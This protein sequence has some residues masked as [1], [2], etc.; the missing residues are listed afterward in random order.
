MVE[1]LKQNQD[2]S[3]ELDNSV[4]E[5]VNFSETKAAVDEAIQNEDVIGPIFPISSSLLE[6][7]GLAAKNA[8]KTVKVRTNPDVS[9]GAPYMER[10]HDAMRRIEYDMSDI[11]KM[12]DYIKWKTYED[13]KW[14][15]LYLDYI[16]STASAYLLTEIM[17]NPFM[18]TIEDINHAT[19]DIIRIYNFKSPETPDAMEY[20]EDRVVRVLQRK[21]G[22]EVDGK[23]GPIFANAL[24]D[25]LMGK[26]RYLMDKTRREYHLEKA[27]YD[28][29]KE[30]NRNTWNTWNTWNW[31]NNLK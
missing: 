26:L 6:A 1:T 5:N 31:P 28:R 25:H 13:L 17:E 12:R 10:L 18:A 29:Q 14:D 21:F 16:Y 20:N 30:Q 8:L 23:P 2:Q 15:E 11:H 22:I 27:K 4:A 7:I 24:L 3:L 19:E 9:T